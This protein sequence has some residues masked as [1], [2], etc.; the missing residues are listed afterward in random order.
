ML[1]PDITLNWVNITLES[2]AITLETI[3]IALERVDM[4]CH[5]I[6]RA[7]TDISYNHAIPQ[8]AYYMIIVS[9]EQSLIS[10]STLVG[11]ADI[12]LEARVGAGPGLASL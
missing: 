3:D 12:I 2:A 1:K 4:K 9:S 6:T 8:K 10:P 11:R 5:D 7:K